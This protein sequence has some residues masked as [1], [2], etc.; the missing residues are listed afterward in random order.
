MS[1]PHIL[2]PRLPLRTRTR[3]R[4]AHHVDSL[5]AWLCRTRPGSHV[6]EW[7]WRACRMW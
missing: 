5:C 7:V 3:L 1:Q 2:H 4:S 6:A